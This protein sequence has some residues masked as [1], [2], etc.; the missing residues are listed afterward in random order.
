M[1]LKDQIFAQL[2]VLLHGWSPD[3]PLS[4]I[5]KPHA[6]VLEECG[7]SLLLVLEFFD[8]DGRRLVLTVVDGVIAA[9]FGLLH[10]GLLVDALKLTELR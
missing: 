2:F 8:V 10:F 5:F 9:D 7:Y 4:A 3:A 6:F 1:R